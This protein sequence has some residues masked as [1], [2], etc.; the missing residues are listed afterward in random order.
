MSPNGLMPR[1]A[2]CLSLERHRMFRIMF[3]R[4]GVDAFRAAKAIQFSI[5]R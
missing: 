3:Q 4:L 1:C 5:S 2:K